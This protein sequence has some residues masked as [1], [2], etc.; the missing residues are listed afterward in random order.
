M[1]R[2]K[3]TDGVMVKYNDDFHC[4]HVNKWINTA[5]LTGQLMECNTPKEVGK[6]SL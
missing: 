3:V 2:G 5:G 1:L 6:T 4:G